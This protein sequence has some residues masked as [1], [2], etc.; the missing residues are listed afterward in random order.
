[1]VLRGRCLRVAALAVSASLLFST[2]PAL[3][4]EGVDRVVAV[5]NG[6]EI[7]MS[8]VMRLA[9]DLPPQY[10]QQLS[11]IIPTLIDRLVDLKLLA[12]AG[13]EQGFAGDERVKAAIVAAESEAIRQVYLE[14]EINN[15]TTDEALEAAYA[16]YLEVNPPRPQLAARHI[17]LESEEDARAVIAELDGG[18]DFAELAKE[19]ST[20]PSAPQGGDLGTFTPEQMVP[21]FSAA[22]MALDVGAYT[23]D[24]VQ[25]QF[26]WHV[27]LL[28][29]RAETEPATFDAIENDLRQQMAREIVEGLLADLR[30][31]AEIEMVDLTPEA[32]SPEEGASEEGG[33]APEA[34]EPT[35]DNTTAD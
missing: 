24:P 18:A 9:Q 16:N 32:E 29:D 2:G 1:M 15:R 11:F 35:P 6:D 28:E 33:E 30:N 34:D 3:T 10:Q 26:G 31:D 27:I 8:D 12:D 22:A 17:L 14:S 20:G 21:P 4:Q 5:V 13:R 7:T 25:T 23:K 19:R